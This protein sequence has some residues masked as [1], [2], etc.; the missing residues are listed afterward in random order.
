MADGVPQ[1]QLHAKPCVKFVSH[2][3]IPFQLHAA[4]DDLFP[5]KVQTFF[6]QMGKEVR[7]IEN[8]IL[9]DLGTAVPE[10]LPGQGVQG[11]NVAQHQTGLAEGACQ[12]FPGGKV[13]G[14]L[15]AYRGIHRRQQGGGDLDEADAPQEAGSSKACQISHHAAPQGDNEIGT[16][17]MVLGQGVQQIQKDQTVFGGF[18]GRKDIGKYGK[19]G[20]FQTGLGLSSVQRPYIGIGDDADGL[21][22]FQGGGFLPQLGHKAAADADI[23]CF[24]CVYGDG[25]HPSTSSL[26]CFPSCRRAV[27]RCRSSA[28]MASR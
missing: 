28:A 16:G 20:V 27:S 18:S 2:H 10:N 15:A 13:N 17:D 5:V 22:P 24:G 4:G 25:V 26:R 6:L 3:H 1:V 14:S 19:T 23:V 12:V 7:I 9:D 8:T 11:V 21:G